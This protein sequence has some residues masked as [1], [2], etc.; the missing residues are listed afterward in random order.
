MEFLIRKN[1][2]VR[3]WNKHW[4]FCVGSGHAAL[5]LRT[6]YTKQLKFIHDELGIERVRFHGIFCDDMHTLHT[7][8]DVI[9][10][11][12][13][14]NFTEQ[15]FRL[16]GLAYDNVLAAGMKPF[17]ELS[18]MPALLAKKKKR[19]MFFYRPV[20]S[21]PKSDAAWEVYIQAFVR[22]LIDRY[23]KEEVES[24]FFEVWNEPDL[25]IAFFDGTQADYFHLYEVTAKAIKSVDPRI[26][27]GGP[28]TS[29]SKWVREFVAHCRQNG[30]P[31]D[32]ITTH[33][34]AGDPLGG[35][36]SENEEEKT[37]GKDQISGSFKLSSLLHPFGNLKQGTVLEAFRTFRQDKSETT[38]IPYG[39]F[40]TNSKIVR[41]QAE[42]LPVYYTEWNAN[43]IF[44]AASN[45]TRKVAAYDVRAALAVEQDVT[46]S[47]IWCFSDIFEELHPFPEEFHGGFGLLTQSGIPKP[48]FHGLKLLNRAGDERYELDGA[49]DGEV[50]MAAF[51]KGDLRQVLLM[52]QKMKNAP[53][54]A[55]TV[56]VRME[57]ESAPKRL[58]LLRIDETHGNP[59]KLWQDMGSPQTPTPAQIEE[60]KKRSAMVEEQ[61]EYRYSDG[62]L[63]F[64]CKL[65]VNDIYF[66]EI[67]VERG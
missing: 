65:G 46:G 8:A 15:S 22:F 50:Q 66:I 30:L 36:D 21:M 48:A 53:L 43:A 12:G 44:S 51:R 58:R 61:Q 25:R 49:M 7:M 11:P 59:L 38:D 32:F 64:T 34:Y 47:S 41:R 19:G 14:G 40:E 37:Q 6:D 42:G 26:R 60:L 62:V 2:P 20:I 23:G 35:I 67:E 28:A 1:T 33:Q 13:G 56:N 27:V 16:C 24:W 63:V 55:E 9:P 31:L 4:Q 3:P 45:D 29:G 17:V 5:A 54:P 10:L 39:V 52:R 57:L 18:F